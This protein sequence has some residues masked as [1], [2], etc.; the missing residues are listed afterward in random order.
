[1]RSAR[2]ILRSSHSPAYWPNVAST[3][4]GTTASRIEAFLA[5]G[6]HDPASDQPQPYGQDVTTRLYEAGP[7]TVTGVPMGVSGQTWAAVAMGI[8]THPLLWGEP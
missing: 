2:S 8:S 5:A 1:V 7:I 4:M 6:L 3:S